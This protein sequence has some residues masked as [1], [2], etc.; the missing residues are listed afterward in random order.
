M[1]SLPISLCDA[2]AGDL[3]NFKP[4]T[5]RQSSEVD[6]PGAACCSHILAEFKRHDERQADIFGATDAASFPRPLGAST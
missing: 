2:C 3:G 5:V 4:I 6:H 1:R